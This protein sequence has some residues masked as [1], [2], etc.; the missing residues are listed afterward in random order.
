MGRLGGSVVER[1]PLARGMIPGS[2]E[3]VPHWTSYME[4][5]SPSAYVSVSV[6]VC[7]YLMN[8]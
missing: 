1:L 2:R 5:A 4:P 3:P 8:K 7:V 6:C